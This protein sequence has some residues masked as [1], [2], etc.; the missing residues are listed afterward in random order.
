MPEIEKTADGNIKNGNGQSEREVHTVMVFMPPFFAS[1]FE[2][3]VFAVDDDV[4]KFFLCVRRGSIFVAAFVYI[5]ALPAD[6]DFIVAVFYVD[7]AE[8]FE[9]AG[10][11]VFRF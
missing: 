4:S 11:F 2:R 6:V 7:S 3:I 9:L 5:D 1:L 8:M 10:W